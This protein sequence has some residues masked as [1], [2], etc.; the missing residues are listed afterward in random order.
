MLMENLQKIDSNCA[1]Y[2]MA[3]FCKILP[4]DSFYS[5]TWQNSFNLPEFNCFN[6]SSC[7]AGALY[8]LVHRGQFVNTELLRMCLN[9]TLLR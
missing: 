4:R 9:S 5:A 6:H 1:Q 3:C 7:D 8:Q 2:A